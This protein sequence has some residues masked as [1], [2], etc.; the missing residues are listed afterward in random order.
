MPFLSIVR[1]A[2]VDTR[3]RT[4]RPSLSTQKRCVRRFG[5]KRRFVLLLACDTLLPDVARFPV[6]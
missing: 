2:A 3:R 1:M 6:T 4:Q 5:L